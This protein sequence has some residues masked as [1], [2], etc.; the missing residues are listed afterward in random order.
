MIIQNRTSRNKFDIFG[1]K[2]GTDTAYFV[3]YDQVVEVEIT[4][5]DKIIIIESFNLIS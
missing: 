4:I 3:I 5:N 1:H 2:V